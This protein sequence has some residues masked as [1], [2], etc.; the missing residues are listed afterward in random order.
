M[1]QKHYPKWQVLWAVALLCI[2]L[3]SC[4]DD[5]EP[6]PELSVSP[7]SITL[8]A[9]G[10]ECEYFDI[11]SNTEWN[12][13]VSEY[14]LEVSE[15]RGK[16]DASIEV[17]A[18]EE[19]PNES[20]RTATITITAGNLTKRV[21][22][23]QEAGQS[24][25]V[26]PQSPQLGAEKGATG[27]IT[28][29]ANSTWSISGLPSWLTLSATQGT[30]IT[31]VTMT[32]T[33]KNFSDKPRTVSLTV[34]AGTKSATLTVTQA[35]FFESIHVS[36]THELIMSDAFYA[37]L[38]FDS[39]VLGY[40]EGY[41]YSQAFST[42]TEE[43]IYNEVLDGTSFSAEDYNYT[44]M[45]GL[46]PSTD[47]VYCCIPYSGDSKT[48]KYGPMLI[49]KFQTKSSSTYCDANVT[50]SYNTSYWTYTISKQQRCHHYYMLMSTNASAESFAKYPGILLALRIRN[51]IED[52]EA[53]PNYDYYLNDGTSRITKESD[54]YAFFLW[55][56]GVDDEGAF[57]GN[58][59]STYQNT[60]SSATPPV[61]YTSSGNM[62]SWKEMTRKQLDAFGQ[63][64][65][66]VR[67]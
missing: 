28:I 13:D 47:Y 2:S 10:Q 57:S 21:R 43:E 17:Y 16:G 12:I 1:R 8:A 24:L 58:I 46:S 7:T 31:A 41:Y 42:K 44:I 25:S 49:K 48:R 35:A 61:P 40:L 53:Y 9:T 23:T 15:E 63:D 30:G 19:N 5:D 65:H 38:Q 3:A 32:T 11:E 22:V 56:W 34:V 64:L 54:D 55:T 4:G 66:V 67:K 60:T 29:T 59:H 36:T 62:R 33:E 27:S 18:T 14:W 20:K 45:Y 51:R 50:S 6:K 39:N 52:K 37:D 26:S